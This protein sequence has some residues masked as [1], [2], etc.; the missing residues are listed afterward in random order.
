MCLTED[1]KQSFIL[2]VIEH[3]AAFAFLSRD[4]AWQHDIL[5]KVLSMFDIRESHGECST[6]PLKALSEAAALWVLL[7]EN[8]PRNGNSANIEDHDLMAVRNMVGFIQRGYIDALSLADI[9]EAGAMGISKCCRL[10]AKYFEQ[11][12]VSYLNRHRLEHGAELL[13]LTDKSVT[14][15]TLAVGFDGASYFAESF[16]KWSGQSP[17][18]FRK[19]RM[20]KD[21]AS[22]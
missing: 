4:V 12:P 16:R 11:S 14:E 3:G 18:E 13:R 2:P 9:A 22:R 19:A 8:L 1:F 6:A 7:F 17:T 21:R 5:T 20:T 10:F 15:I